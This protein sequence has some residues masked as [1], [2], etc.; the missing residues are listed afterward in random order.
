LI[1]FRGLSRKNF[2]IIFAVFIFL[3]ALGN[4]SANDIDDNLDNLTDTSDDIVLSSE[5][6]NDILTDGE[7]SLRDLQSEINSAGDSFT[8]SRDYKYKSGDSVDGIKITKKFTL[9]GNGKTI[10]A[11]G[12]A[13]VFNITG[14]DV[15]LKNIIIKNAF[16]NNTVN[17]NGQSNNNVN[18]SMGNGAG[19]LWSGD[20]GQLI[21][22][23]IINATIYSDVRF[24][25]MQDVNVDYWMGNG[26]GVFW[27]GENGKIENTKFTNNTLFTNLVIKYNTYSL[28]NCNIKRYI[29]NGVAL[30]MTGNNS[31]IKR[32]NFTN[33][34]QNW[35]YNTTDVTGAET[36]VN[37]LG[38]SISNVSLTFRGGS[39]WLRGS[40]ITVSDSIVSGNDV[41][42]GSAI[43]WTGHNG[44]LTTSKINNNNGTY[45]TV[46]W[47]GANGTITQSSFNNNTATQDAS[48]YWTGSNGL[49][50]DSTF[51][52]STGSSYRGG[53]EWSGADGRVINCNFTN[54][55]TGGNEAAFYWTGTNGTIDNCNFINNTARSM[56]GAGGFNS[57]HGQILNS[58][59]INNHVSN[60]YGGAIRLQAYSITVNNCTFINNSAS[61]YGGAI[62]VNSGDPSI[63]NSKF[64]NNSAG[65]SGDAIFVNNGLG[66]CLENNTYSN[67]VNDLRD[68]VLL[69]NHDFYVSPNGMGTGTSRNPSD[70][71]YAYTKIAHSRKIILLEGTYTN[72]VNQS[73]T[74]SLTITGQGN[75]VIDANKTGR[76]FIVTGYKTTIS[77]ITFKN[78][79]MTT[80]SGGLVRWEG[81]YGT[82]TDCTFLNGYAYYSSS[83]GG[84]ICWTG[85]YGTLNHSVFIN[86]TGNN[87][88][89]GVGGAVYWTGIGGIVEYSNFTNNVATI[90]NDIYSTNNLTLN[91]NIFTGDYIKSNE[92]VLSGFE[93]VYLKITAPNEN[94]TAKITITNNN[95]VTT[96]VDN[97]IIANTTGNILLNLNKL[98]AGEYT[99]DVSFISTNNKYYNTESK[100]IIVVSKSTV[101]YVSSN[102]TGTGEDYNNPTTLENAL[103]QIMYNTTIVFVNGTH[104]IIN[105]T[106]TASNL[107][108]NGSGNTILDAEHLGR[109]FIIEGVN[110]TLNKLTFIN[111][112]MSG[113]AGVL[114]WA[115]DYG[116]LNYCNFTNNS[117]TGY[118]AAIRWNGN[119]GTMKY[120]NI[121]NNTNIAGNQGGVTW[122]GTNALIN[123]CIFVNNTATVS[124]GALYVEGAD[125]KVINSEFRNNNA[126][127]FGGALVMSR[128]IYVGNCIFVDN[129]AGT[130]GGSIVSYDNSGEIDNCTFK[131]NN[132]TTDG[133]AIYISHRLYNVHDCIFINN[134][135]SNSNDIYNTMDVIISNNDF[136]GDY[137]GIPN[138]IALG[139]N[140]TNYLKV[141]SSNVN[142]TATLSIAGQSNVIITVVANSTGDTVFYLPELPAGEYTASI[143][144][145]GGNN[146]YTNNKNIIFVIKDSVLYVKVGGTGTGSISDK[147]NITYAL[148]HAIDGSVIMV[149]SGTYNI[150]DSV[151]SKSIKIIGDGGV[152][153]DA[154]SNGRIFIVTGLGVVLENLKF[155]NGYTTVDSDGENGRGG[156]VA[157]SGE[158]GLINNC[159]FKS[160]IAVRGG[161]LLCTGRNFQVINSTFDS[162]KATA[163][164][165]A[166]RWA[167]VNG[168]IIGCTFTKNTAQDASALACIA[169]NL[170][171][172]DSLFESNIASDEATVEWLNGDGNLIN[173]TFK[174]NRNNYRGAVW[175]ESGEKYDVVNCTFINCT[176]ISGGG[177]AIYVG[178]SYVTVNNT[179]FINNSG[180]DAGAIRW[181]GRYGLI[182]NSNFTNNAGTY[183]G[184]IYWSS[185]Y[186]NI[187]N[188][189]F[190]NNAGTYGGAIYWSSNYGNISNSKFINNTANNVNDIYKTVN[191]L[192]I[193]NNT[194]QGSYITLPNQITVNYGL[195]N[196]IKVTSMNEE[197]NI[198]VKITGDDNKNYNFTVPANSI[199]DIVLYLNDLNPGNYNIDILFAHN[200][201]NKFYN[202]ART[203]IVLESIFYVKVGGTGDGSEYDESSFN[204]ALSHAIDGT[205]IILR[206]GNYT[207]IRNANIDKSVIIRGSANTILDGNKANKIFVVSSDNVVL[208]NIIFQNAYSTSRGGA[209]SWNGAYGKII[210]CT[211]VNNTYW[212]TGSFSGGALYSNGQYLN[213]TNCTFADN[214]AMQTSGSADGGAVAIQG[215]YTTIDRT[216]FKNNKAYNYG[217]AL[218][219]N[220][221]NVNVMN[222]IFEN[223]TAGNGNGG[224]IDFYNCNYGK[225]YNCTFINNSAIGAG[226]ALNYNG[227]S[228]TLTIDNCVFE[229]NSATTN[230]GAL[231]L[232]QNSV[233]VKNSIF[234]T[235]TAKTGGAIYWSGTSGSL[236]YC[237]F[238]DNIAVT[239]SNVYLSNGANA[240]MGNNIYIGSYASIPEEVTNDFAIVTMGV[241]SSRNIN[242]II[243]VNDYT[244]STIIPA[245]SVGDTLFKIPDF[246]S[247]G[248]YTLDVTFITPESNKYVA[249]SSYFDVLPDALYV[250]IDG[251][252]DG[253]TRDNPCNW[254][255][256]MNHL[257]TGVKLI[258]LD[259]EYNNI[260]NQTIN[261]PISIIGSNNTVINAQGKGR[262]FVVSANRVILKNLVIRNAY[263]IALGGAVSWNGAYGEIINCTFVNNTYW[264]T[265]SYSGGALYSNGQYLNITNCTF[266]DNQAMQTSGSADGGAVAIQGE[267]TT[268]D[269]S[270]FKNNKAIDYAGGIIINANNCNI[271]NCLFENNTAYNSA[272]GISFYNCN[273]GFIYNCTFIDNH[274][275]YGGA[276]R[277]NGGGSTLTID[278]CSFINNSATYGGSLGIERNTVTVKNSIFN[279]NSADYGGAV[280]WSG[281]NGNIQ[282]S[283][284]K[285]NYA[286]TLHDIYNT[287]TDL[288]V[289]Y[290]NFTGSYLIISEK[291]LSSIDTFNL[292]VSPLQ[293]TVNVTINVNGENVT[294]LSIPANLIGDSKITINGL[295]GIGNVI[296]V[297]YTTDG[298]NIYTDN[299]Y[300]VDV[301]DSI[302]LYVSPNGGGN[303]YSENSPTT[304]DDAMRKVTSDNI[305]IIVFNGTY[306]VN[307][308]LISHSVKIIGKGNVT[309]DA[310]HN[311]RIL[312]VTG[313]NVV[314]ENLK[315]IN[316]YTTGDSDGDYGRGGAVAWS[317]EYGLINN[318]TFKSNIAVRG[319]A[320]L[321]T[322][323]NLQVINSTFDSNKA[324]AYQG[325]IRWAS[326]NGQ[327]IGCTFT[328]NTAY[329]GSAM[330]IIA[331]NVTIQDSIFTNNT[332]YDQGTIEWTAGNGKVINST[333]INNTIRTDGVVFLENSNT[334]LID[335]C[336]FINNNALSSAGAIAAY[337]NYITVKNS[338][339]INN[340]AGY[341]GGSIYWSA[342]YGLLENCTF[343][344][345]SATNGGGAIFWNSNDPVS[346][347]NNLKFYNNTARSG[348]AIFSN[349]KGFTV[350]NS[351]FGDNNDS[352]TLSYSFTANNLTIT[353]NGVDHYLNGIYVYGNSNVVLTN[354]VTFWNGGVKT[355]PT[356]T[357]YRNAKQNVNIVIE[358]YDLETGDFINSYNG[359]TNSNGKVTFDGWTLGNYHVVAYHNFG[360]SRNIS[361]EF[362]YVNMIYV[363]VDGNGTGNNKS[364]PTNL[365][366]ALSIY[367]DGS[368]IFLNGGTYNITGEITIDKSVTIIGSG[369]DTI[370]DAVNNNRILKVTADDVSI[371]NVTFING[372]ANDG[373]AIYWT[374]KNGVLNNTKF[375]NNTARDGSAIYTTQQLKIYNSEFLDNTADVDFTYAKTDDSFNVHIVNHDN[376][377]NAIHASINPV[378]QNVT[379][380]GDTGIVTDNSGIDA[381]VGH[382]LTVVL[383]E[384]VEQTP[385]KTESFVTDSNGNITKDNLAKNI[386]Y[387]VLVKHYTGLTKYKSILFDIP[388]NVT[389]SKLELFV[390]SEIKEGENLTVIALVNSTA[391]G[392]LNFTI[393]G[394][395][396]GVVDIVDGRAVL[397]VNPNLTIGNYELVVVY[398]ST[399]G[400]YG[401]RNT[402]NFTVKVKSPASISVIAP[403]YG[404]NNTV[405]S[406]SAK[407]NFIAPTELQLVVR[408]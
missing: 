29:G 369:D 382:N 290:N 41:M 256:A 149:E 366:Y 129:F 36:N 272:G 173:S 115:G 384:R 12:M 172:R 44:T 246:L 223:N 167:S 120:C 269:K 3:I 278:N 170:T 118:G 164:Q 393:N 271:T 195:A 335:N 90:C 117:C 344:N 2:L 130:Y 124:A 296:K 155:V 270:I 341:M 215:A 323:R 333:F 88:L 329:D 367:S 236:M 349:N 253:W 189:N 8:L 68:A 49:V 92:K 217:G 261:I 285:N 7:G 157:W 307:N 381:S 47:I 379:Y 91:N 280:Y 352:S 228:S 222:S 187:S 226:G 62:S 138:S 254:E 404:V 265:G 244:Y 288:I 328:N 19:I 342:N 30:V 201:N 96:T 291:I 375:Y 126:S 372:N 100:I 182:T 408:L 17:L 350:S 161:A 75:V 139:Y 99:I 185:N 398:D 330:A 389:V 146:K 331:S 48:F 303:G 321:C 98:N 300:V 10:D 199:E 276:L 354:N 89:G 339:F 219:I 357:I 360:S 123:H 319:G 365:T 248:F 1:G 395:S 299:G 284:F 234:N 361:T 112:N 39:L 229:N 72:I 240:V 287:R 207:E 377:I 251:T 177:G 260:V 387:D 340:R 193:N 399:N 221:A 163:F 95:H 122:M 175:F 197:L 181:S 336:T 191:N 277:Y 143:N 178:V 45:Y 396:I 180:I 32:S 135:A 71:Y 142:V 320:L 110:I 83:G 109:V 121:F 345:N 374:G 337:V 348:S 385:I 184:A 392:T 332:A 351:V 61:T 102:G 106:I 238:S 388:V 76:I 158:Y 346:A 401:Q 334:Y 267:Y 137:V 264:G 43:F 205:I 289:E 11:C 105:Q 259:G 63:F 198:T 327:I 113:D 378:L 196:L 301:V 338:K 304:W 103:T 127:T 214:Q 273:N 24:Q 169:N 211:F 370:F 390:P 233:T 279:E 203:L 358:L 6:S 192:I 314:L 186:G 46:Y 55:T 231:N 23:Q 154:N 227:G 326:V 26:A 322:E 82:L 281:S 275:G 22:S 274:A 292:E 141:R 78:G 174:N 145:V 237:N 128:N 148:E 315:F 132:A 52:N 391:Q 20:N 160:N 324:T 373:G 312:V 298:S 5:S 107:I 33:N 59:F 150:N 386:Y 316:G 257:Y 80:S 306:K 258:L 104:N 310:N 245:G 318:C 224:G 286:N 402:T 213:I 266:A 400:F 15:V 383:S 249:K 84:A 368:I 9:D 263:S 343:E 125:G 108:I 376:Y 282:Y 111:G 133:G 325:A 353:Y 176:A 65:S 4:V 362:D 305:T 37:L 97:I 134:T 183:G 51:I 21:N 247:P 136:T 243:K 283:S 151:V 25:N 79:N 13:R 359:F 188:S 60:G 34:K 363:S 406:I 380:W 168:Q 190:T 311:G 202:Y 93:D 309:L 209:I 297:Y 101:I 204:Y 56:N 200:T 394:K 31:S 58:R 119:Y 28:T 144:F 208:E 313:N 114:Y 162:N 239:S 85:S 64:I 81:Q 42:Y 153:F 50:S 40:Q 216:V 364:N 230:G 347:L 235:N 225:V 140:N 397:S 70:W 252:G 53:F 131:N 262:V 35:T 220:V 241:S 255:Y 212:G 27:T 218:D 87:S 57:V 16:I 371:C 403:E 294:N 295:S 210:N 407:L 18:I 147:C 74:K 356:D 166:I 159:T 293:Y 179:I 250:S 152:T 116:V 308:E 165:G 67:N 355:T 206:S 66:I 171:I 405:L 268:I 242:A 73:I 69:E 194:F 94:I 14:N 302:T 77:R 156:A 317:G 38:S 232:Q 86:N 54:L